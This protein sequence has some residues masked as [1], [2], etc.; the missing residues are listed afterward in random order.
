MLIRWEQMLSED[1]PLSCTTPCSKLVT[2]QTQAGGTIAQRQCRPGICTQGDW[3]KMN[4]ATMNML[5][6][7]RV[8]LNI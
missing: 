6:T 8:A 4:G 3:P 1:S 2:A 7:Q 5:R